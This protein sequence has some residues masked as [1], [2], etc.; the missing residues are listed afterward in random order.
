MGGTDRM[1]LKQ[2]PGGGRQAF[3]LAIWSPNPLGDAC[4]AMPAVRAV[5]RSRDDFRLT[6]CCRENLA[7]VWAAQPEVDEV[8][9]FAKGLGP[10]RVGRAVRFGPSWRER[11]GSGGTP[12]GD[13]PQDARSGPRQFDAALLFPNSLR[14][15][16]EA[17]AAGIPLVAGYGGGG[18]RLLLHRAI[19]KVGEPPPEFGHHAFHYLRLVE[20]VGGPR[21]TAEA[22]GDAPPPP[23]PIGSGI[24]QE[25]SST[26]ERSRA[27]ARGLEIH[28]GI[29][30]GAEYGEA[31]RYPVE[32]YAAAVADLRA[33]RPDL[34]IR[35]SLFGSPAERAIGEDLA[36]RI[37]APVENRVG[38]TGLGDLVEELRTC[39]LL[40]TNDTGTMH[41]AAAL[42]VPVVAVFG[43]TEP[44]W[45][46]P[47]GEGHRIVRH[48]VECSP[49]FRR[50]CPID[51]RCMLRI[52]PERL[53]DEMES[54]LG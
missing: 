29:C 5:A 10:I 47:L 54:L 6:V 30:P 15:A 8:I 49:C 26:G 23:R 32:R 2:S 46:A 53:A 45:T 20:A 27:G 42:G 25:A 13:G 3:R 19:G 51:Y 43:S 37:E 21:V 31:K 36:S 4:M 24:A 34:A 16:L 52:P 11:D 41:L 38:R 40:A 35:V 1:L 17:R 39:H 28:L 50:E 18:R 12:G 7:P 9:A 48:R 14:S 22:L 44:A 33:R